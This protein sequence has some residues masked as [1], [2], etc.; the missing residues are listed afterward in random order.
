LDAEQPKKVWQPFLDWVKRSNDYSVKWPVT[1][2][3]I[4]ARHFWDAE[5]LKEHWPEVILPR[6]GSP[7]HALI[8]DVLVHLIPQPVLEF[9]NRPGAG[10]DNVWFKGSTG[11]C[12]WYIWAFESL[13]LPESL[14]ARSSQERLADALFAASRHATFELHFNTGLAGAPADA[15]AGAKDTATNPAVLTA[16]ALVIAGDSQG[17]AYPGI[18]RHEP[19]IT[20]GR[21]GAQRVDQCVNELRAI[22]PEDGAYVS[23]SNYF[24]KNWQQSYWGNNYA[25]LAEIK[26]KYDPEGLFIVHNGVGS[27][28]WSADGF[29]KL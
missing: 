10:S 16:F 1:I 13:W 3:S 29:T 20:E 28:G 22:F 4:P 27:E 6:N 11:E 19:S 9:D 15:I 14:L 5:W 25:R 21:E 18:P 24:Q 8:D 2:G 7:M 17:P 26:K 12:G 23:E